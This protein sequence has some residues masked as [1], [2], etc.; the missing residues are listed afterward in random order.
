MQNVEVVAETEAAAALARSVGADAALLLAADD[1]VSLTVIGED[2]E[3]T[4]VLASMPIGSA[5]VA[6]A[7]AAVLQQAPE[8]ATRVMLVGQRLDLDSVAAELRSTTTPVEVP[9]DPGFAIARGAAQ[10]AAD[11]WFAPAGA[12]PDGTGCLDATQMAPAAGDATQM[13]PAAG[14]ATQMAPAAGDATQ[15]APASDWR[16]RAAAGVLAGRA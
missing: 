4:S 13:A 3:S 1:T 8:A 9:P 6:V 16:C 7:C 5:G 15:M 10:T 14:D 11:P 12:A 2:E